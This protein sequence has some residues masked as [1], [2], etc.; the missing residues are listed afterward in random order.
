MKKWLLFYAL[1]LSIVVVDLDM[2]AVNLALA[3]IANELHLSLSTAQ[4]VIDGYTIAAA[5]LAALGGRLGEIYGARRTL[6]VTLVFFA[7]ASLGVG[8][9]QDALVIIIGRI[10][11]GCCTA[12]I[13]PVAVVA[14]RSVFPMNKQGFI[15]G[16][17]VSVA[18]LAQALGPTFGGLMIEYFDWRWIFLI[19]V[20]L[21]AVIM[22]AVFYLPKKEQSD[23]KHKISSKAVGYLVGGLFLV[24]LALN[25]V[26]RW[27][28]SSW[29]FWSSLIIGASLLILFVRFE[30]REDDPLLELKLLINKVCAALNVIRIL[31]FFVYFTYLFTLSLYLQ[32]VLDYTAMDAGMTLLFM[33]LVF[34]VFSVPCGRAID[35]FGY[36]KPLL[37]SIILL[38]ATSMM[39]AQFSEDT[40]IYYLATTLVLAGIAIAS[41]VPSTTVGCLQETPAHKNGAT[42]GILITSGF[43][44]ISLG[45][46]ISGSLL[47]ILNLN[48]AKQ[49][50]TGRNLQL[51]LEQ[52]QSI[53]GLVTGTK[54][55][56]KGL[57]NFPA[58]ITSQALDVVHH[59]FSFGFTR[60]MWLCAFLCVVS[61]VIKMRYVCRKKTV[62]E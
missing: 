4:W 60:V 21:S 53:Q 35:K 62:T 26:A 56:A 32:N 61:F 47:S 58:D 40:S 22:F 7:I 28:L 38:F 11:Q 48:K 24:M 10:L 55:V 31:L 34:G 17:M 37:I 5:A 44:G 12:I 23:D 43:I 16:M 8:L 51:T 9:S 6:M 50:L 30:L 36:H 18:S 29:Q 49:L 57:E 27:G 33:T 59:S 3:T 46:A 39:M 14:A 42:T 13:M 54:P 41:L 25:E 15:I 20:P 45:V 52:K 19:N 2:T 1:T